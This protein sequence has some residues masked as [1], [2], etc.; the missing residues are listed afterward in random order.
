M[1]HWCGYVVENFAEMDFKWEYVIKW[2]VGTHKN[3]SMGL[4]ASVHKIL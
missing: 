3:S 2:A 1:C 4:C